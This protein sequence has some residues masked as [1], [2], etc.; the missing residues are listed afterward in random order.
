MSC[1][2]T[3]RAILARRLYNLRPEYAAEAWVIYLYDLHYK[4]AHPR[5]GYGI[6]GKI[7]NIE[8]HKYFT[9]FTQFLGFCAIERIDCRI[10]LNALSLNKNVW[11]RKFPL[12]NMLLS[13]RAVDC[14]NEYLLSMSERYPNADARR[15][16]VTQL[17]NAITATQIKRKTIQGRSHGIEKNI[18]LEIRNCLGFLKQQIEYGLFDPEESLLFDFD[19]L[20]PY[21]GYFVPVWHKAL[22]VTAWDIV[23][24]LLADNPKQ[25][26]AVLLVIR[27]W[28]SSSYKDDLPVK[29]SNTFRKLLIPGILNTRDN[30]E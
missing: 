18:R 17:P 11:R 19:Y 21:V 29:V 23:F 5:L 20:S 16:V 9:Y 24:K 8:R 10:Y 25:K 3:W 13:R 7:K 27:E 6:M 12:P 28:F 30:R 15:F 22:V 1:L 14:Y 2:D 4:Q 26:D